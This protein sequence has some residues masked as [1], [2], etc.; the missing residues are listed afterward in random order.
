MENT[1]NGERNFICVEDVD[2]YRR[3]QGED[4]PERP[5]AEETYVRAP[6]PHGIH[7][8]RLLE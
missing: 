3:A 8:G 6:E 5:L 2:E 4:V 7:A 1:P